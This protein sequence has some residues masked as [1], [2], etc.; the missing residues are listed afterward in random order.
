MDDT[1]FLLK[2]RISNLKIISTTFALVSAFKVNIEKDITKGVTYQKKKRASRKELPIKQ[3][4]IMKGVTINQD[5]L[6]WQA[7]CYVAIRVSSP[8]G[9]QIL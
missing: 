4:G 5:H 7:L 2:Q 8:S 9:T 6:E 3:K 1:D